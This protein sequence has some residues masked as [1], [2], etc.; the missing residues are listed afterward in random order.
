MAT[1]KSAKKRIK[2]AAK[3]RLRNRA[4]MSSVR[5]IVKNFR[6]AIT[7][8]EGEKAK[9]FQL[10]QQSLAKAGQKGVINKKTVSRKISRLSKMLAKAK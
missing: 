3:T 10:A 7:T 4:K 8:G 1:H 2:T 5:N 9:L 6:E